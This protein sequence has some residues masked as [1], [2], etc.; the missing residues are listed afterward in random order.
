MGCMVTFDWRFICSSGVAAGLVSSIAIPKSV[1]DYPGSNFRYR[2]TLAY[3]VLCLDYSPRNRAVNSRAISHPLIYELLKLGYTSVI[4]VHLGVK[5]DGT[6][7]YDLLLSQQFAACHTSCLW[8]VYIL[9]NNTSAY[10]ARC[11]SNINI[12]QGSVA[13]SFSC[14]EIC[15]Y[16]CIANFLT[17]VTATEFWK[18]VNIWRSYGQVFGFLFFDSRCIEVLTAQRCRL[19]DITFEKHIFL[20]WWRQGKCH[21]WLMLFWSHI[22]IYVCFT[23]LLHS[24]N[25]Q[26]LNSAG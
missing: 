15:N 9:E 18:S 20:K 16:I 7:Y 26:T 13:T 14:C 11:F 19:S 6:Y 25:A 8:R 17:N 1:S 12:S 21:C 23:L 4:F 2:T 24:S 3:T 22:K 5:V 10:R